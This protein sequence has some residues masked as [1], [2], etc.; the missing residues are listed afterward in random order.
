M[1]IQAL[2]LM[3]Y[4]QNTRTPSGFSK[5]VETGKEYT[6]D[7]TDTGRSG[8]GIA[9]IEGLVIFVKGAK[10]GDKNVKIKVNSVGDRFATAELAAAGSTDTT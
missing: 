1:P 9:R 5:P 6:V 10:A 7:I 3:S 8:D 2:N 4:G